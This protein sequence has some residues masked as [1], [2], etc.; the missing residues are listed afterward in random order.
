MFKN[1][2]VNQEYEVLNTIADVFDWMLND[3]DIYDY[4]H[5]YNVIGTI[6]H[7]LEERGYKLSIKKVEV[8]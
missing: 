1:L 4:D 6:M 8:E 5:F 3:D 7:K 2:N